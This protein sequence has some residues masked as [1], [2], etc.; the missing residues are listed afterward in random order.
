MVSLCR[1]VHINRDLTVTGRLPCI[2]NNSIKKLKPFAANP[3]FVVKILLDS[4]DKKDFKP[5]HKGQQ[6]DDTEVVKQE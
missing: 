5:Q 2:G 4:I 6:K 1:L 3:K